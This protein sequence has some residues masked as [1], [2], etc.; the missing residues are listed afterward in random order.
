MNSVYYYEDV[1]AVAKEQG[2]FDSEQE[3]RLE[4]WSSDPF[5]WGAKYGFP[6]A[7]K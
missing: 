4:E 1:L 6:R 7:E 2:R 3:R 5:G